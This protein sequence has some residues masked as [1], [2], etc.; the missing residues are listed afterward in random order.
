MEMLDC[1]ACPSPNDVY[2]KMFYYVRDLLVQFIHRSREVTLLIKIN[3]QNTSILADYI[4]TNYGTEQFDRIEVCTRTIAS[5]LECTMFWVA[6]RNS[7][8]LS[9]I[10]LLLGRF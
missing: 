9:G 1:K 4:W 10:V 3:Y 6:N 2:G 5:F 8:G 7:L